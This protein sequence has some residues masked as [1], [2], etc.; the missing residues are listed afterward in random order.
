MA[1]ELFQ[2]WDEKRFGHITIE[3]LAEQLISFGLATN[4]D[5]VIKLM[6]TVL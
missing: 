6:Q 3:E 1:R 5:Q 4:E 2:V